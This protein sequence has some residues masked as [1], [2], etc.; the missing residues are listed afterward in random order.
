MLE[1]KC[2][3]SLSNENLNKDE[4]KQQ[5]HKVVCLV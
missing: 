4:V 3:I 2:L 1:E 5:K